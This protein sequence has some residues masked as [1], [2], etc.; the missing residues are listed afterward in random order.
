M[1]NRIQ[2]LVKQLNQYRNEYYNDN[3]P[4]VSDYEY[5]NLFDELKQLEEQTGG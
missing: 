1:I 4:T 2:S 3:N 5:D